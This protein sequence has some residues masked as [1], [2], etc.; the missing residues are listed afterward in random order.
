[1][2]SSNSWG[3]SMPDLV[4]FLEGLQG[5]IGRTIAKKDRLYFEV[6]DKDLHDVV[7]HLFLKKG[8]RLSTATAMEMYRGLEVLYHFSDDA[9]GHYFC[10]RVVITDLENPK[11]NSIT[12]IV[13][14]AEWIER[15]MSEL[16]GI[17]FVGHHNPERL[18]TRDHPKAPHQPLRLRRRT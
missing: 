2:P 12:P 18:L 3:C 4:N 6:A 8:C 9:T 7:R 10:P 16:F 11:M 14:G 17:T 13:K 15:E 5:K 1:M